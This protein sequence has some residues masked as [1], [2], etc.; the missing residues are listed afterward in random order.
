MS[1]ASLCE[2][3]EIKRLAGQA[4]KNQAF[5]LVDRILNERLRRE[6]VEELLDR[7]ELSDFTVRD[8]ASD[9]W[10]FLEAFDVTRQ[11]L[12]DILTQ[13]LHTLAGDSRSLTG[14]STLYID[15]SCHVPMF[16]RRTDPSP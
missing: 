9:N 8:N 3:L 5:S 15:T 7:P 14:I 11:E 16:K 10:A 4:A 13:R 12:G 2:L 1:I 6:S